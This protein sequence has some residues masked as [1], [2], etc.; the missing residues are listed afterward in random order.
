MSDLFVLQSYGDIWRKQRRMVA[1]YFTPINIQKHEAQQEKQACIL[2][3]NLLK[4]PSC[5]FPETKLYDTLYSL[6]SIESTLKHFKYR[7]I[8]AIIMH[9]TYGYDLRTPGDPLL[10]F[11]LETMENFNRASMPENFLVNIFPACEF[12]IERQLS[13]GFADQMNFLCSET[14]SPMDAWFQF[15]ENCG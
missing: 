4:D 10:T 3:N 1:Q 15:P 6:S 14:Y 2:V 9:A 11:A 8:G 12:R 5:L 13:S 7:R